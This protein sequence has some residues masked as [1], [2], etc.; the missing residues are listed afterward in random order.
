MFVQVRNHDFA[1]GTGICCQMY[2]Q[3]CVGVTCS[4]FSLSLTAN[5]R[6]V[7]WTQAQLVRQTWDFLLLALLF[8][9]GPADILKGIQAPSFK[10]KI[11]SLTELCTLGSTLHL[12]A[13]FELQAPSY[14]SVFTQSLGWA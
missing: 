13:F 6:T 7:G 8:W 14:A 2:F 1:Q 12:P 11:T 5:P 3:S 9:A 10:K 4:M